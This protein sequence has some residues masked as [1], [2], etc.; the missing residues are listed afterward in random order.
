MRFKNL[1]LAFTII[2]TICTAGCDDKTVVPD[3][4]PGVQPTNYPTNFRVSAV[5]ETTITVS[6]N[7]ATGEVVPQNYLVLAVQDG[8]TP[9]F[10]EDGIKPVADRHT[11]IIP[12]E[13]R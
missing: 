7:D 12:R 10:P 4:T 5:S 1:L 2:S 9:E 13:A 6:W 11:K 8:Y 3:D